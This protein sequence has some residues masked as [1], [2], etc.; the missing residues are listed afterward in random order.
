MRFQVDTVDP[1]S[2]GK[3]LSDVVVRARKLRI[4]AYCKSGHSCIKDG[5]WLLRWPY[6]MAA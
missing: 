4:A 2:R 1:R 5:A 6:C 3:A